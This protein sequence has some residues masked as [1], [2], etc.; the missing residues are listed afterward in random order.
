MEVVAACRLYC[1]YG[2]EDLAPGSYSKRL[3]L[4][5]TARANSCVCGSSATLLLSGI[6]PP[7]MT[8]IRL[9]I[10]IVIRQR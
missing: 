7:L 5:H 10:C 1:F 3:L 4:L 9:E 6:M 8:A 2:A